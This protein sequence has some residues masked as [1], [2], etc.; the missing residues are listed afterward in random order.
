MSTGTPMIS[1]L[2]TAILRSS[3]KMS[4]IILDPFAEAVPA[5]ALSIERGRKKMGDSTTFVE[6]KTNFYESKPFYSKLNETEARSVMLLSPTST[7]LAA[8]QSKN[9]FEILQENNANKTLDQQW[10]RKFNEEKVAHTADRSK[11]HTGRTEHVNLNKNANNITKAKRNKVGNSARNIYRNIP[12][13]RNEDVFHKIGRG[14]RVG[15]DSKKSDGRSLSDYLS[16]FSVANNDRL[17]GWNKSNPE[18]IS[19]EKVNTIYAE[20]RRKKVMTQVTVARE[21]YG[22]R[23]IV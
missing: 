6:N 5:S 16:S 3:I 19:G 10:Y 2:I 14:S 11:K 22:G 21:I 15:K 18:E 13:N 8:E 9:N 17:R 4:I 20:S 23:E 7:D 1:D 12:R